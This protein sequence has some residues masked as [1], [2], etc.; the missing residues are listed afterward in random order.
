MADTKV[1]FF[2]EKLDSG[3]VVSSNGKKKAVGTPEEMLAYLTASFKN[4]TERLVLNVGVR[5]ASLCIETEEN[6]S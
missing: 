5:T 1:E 6:P 4:I 2:I 3:Y